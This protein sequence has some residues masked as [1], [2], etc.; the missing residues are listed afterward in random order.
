MAHV[1]GQ[2]LRMGDTI[3]VPNTTV[4]YE[5]VEIDS[6]GIVLRAE[7]ADLSHERL[8]RLLVRRN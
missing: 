4:L 5:I 7:N 2:V 3:A 1:N 6:D 8:V